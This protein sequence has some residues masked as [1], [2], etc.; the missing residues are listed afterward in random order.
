MIEISLDKRVC[1]FC[2]ANKPIRPSEVMI[3]I[4]QYIADLAKSLINIGAEEE[5]YVSVEYRIL[6]IKP[7]VD[8]LKAAWDH[9]GRPLE[10]KSGE[11][12]AFN[13]LFVEVL[14]D[15]ALFQAKP[16]ED[17][18]VYILSKYSRLLAS[19]RD[20]NAARFYNWLCS[21]Y[22][23][24][25]DLDSS[26]YLSR[27]G[28]GS[29]F[30][31]MH[32][33]LHD[34]QEMLGNTLALLLS[35]EKS[36]VL[37][38]Q[39]SPKATVELCCDFSALAMIST[40]EYERF[41]QCTKTELFGIAMLALFVPGLYAF[42]DNILINNQ[43]YDGD[44]LAQAL[45][46]TANERIK[47]LVVA[48]KLSCNGNLFFGDCDVDAALH[49]ALEPIGDFLKECGSYYLNHLKAKIAQFNSLSEEERE[50]YSFHYQYYEWGLFS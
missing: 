2:A 6:D 21:Q 14:S 36:R 9:L 17:C 15:L 45:F 29:V 20:P 32:E 28:A 24:R 25:P 8:T 38:Q 10:K 47:T 22:E 3:D 1:A 37:C 23:N 48:V 31:L 19:T 41:Y 7:H 30:I 50:K 18:C 5:R 44:I 13:L 40:Y 12:L 42:F 11:V 49:Y 4:G 35:S 39:L 34:Q 33:W 16:D 26:P 43:T 46:N 27:A